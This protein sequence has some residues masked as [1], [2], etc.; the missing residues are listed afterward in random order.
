MC[1]DSNDTVAREPYLSTL[2][3][4]DKLCAEIMDSVSPSAAIVLMG[5]SWGGAV[6]ARVAARFP[7]R[8]SNNEWIEQM[9]GMNGM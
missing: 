1:K 9:N 6:A 7:E 2:E 3:A 4:A 5:K 8:V